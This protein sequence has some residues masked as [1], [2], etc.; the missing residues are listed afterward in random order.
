VTRRATAGARQPSTAHIPK[1]ISAD[2]GQKREIFAFH[3]DVSP[4]M[5]SHVAPT[6]RRIAGEHVHRD[7]HPRYC[8]RRNA[9]YSLLW[10]PAGQRASVPNCLCAGRQGRVTAVRDAPACEPGRPRPEATAASALFCPV[11]AVT[12][13]TAATPRAGESSGTCL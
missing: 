5:R 13:G 3:G 6:L 1:G 12:A 9:R 10:P 11:Y 2:K 7:D 4:L 8:P